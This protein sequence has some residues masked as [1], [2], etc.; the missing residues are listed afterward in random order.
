MAFIFV[1]GTHTFSSQLKGYEHMTVQ[2]QNCGN[3]SGRVYKRWQW[4]TIC[5]I[6][7]IPFSL[8]PWQEVGCH[9]CNFYQ[10][11]KYRPDVQN[12]SAGGAH[13]LGAMPP[14]GQQYGGPPGGPPGGKPQGQYA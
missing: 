5:W 3:F 1:C 7:I 8:K 13:Q 11:I 14:G 2:C 9:I 6:P 10:D 4:F 12:G